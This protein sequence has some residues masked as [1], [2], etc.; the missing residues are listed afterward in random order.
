MER[1]IEAKQRLRSAI[2]YPIVIALAAIGVVILMA[3]FV[4]PQLT[5]FFKQFGVKLRR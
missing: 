2:T 5:K 1:D 4:L 3:E